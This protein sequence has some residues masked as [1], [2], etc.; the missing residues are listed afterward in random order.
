MCEDGLEDGGRGYESRNRSVF[1][2]VKKKKK[3]QGN[4]FSPLEPPKGM[5][6][7]DTLILAQWDLYGASDL[8]NTKVINCVVS[9]NHV[10]GYL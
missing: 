6:P 4:G 7:A 10:C 5:L 8:H 3:K 9:S 1:Q 2:K